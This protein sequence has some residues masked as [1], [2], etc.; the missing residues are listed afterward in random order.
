MAVCFCLY[1]TG[2]KSPRCLDV[3]RCSSRCHVLSA[4][5]ETDLV[6]D[7]F[8][9]GWCLGGGGGKGKPQS[10]RGWAG[11]MLIKRQDL[12]PC[13]IT[14][15]SMWR[16]DPWIHKTANWRELHSLLSLYRQSGFINV[17]MFRCYITFFYNNNLIWILNKYTDRS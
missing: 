7:G 10:R 9:G 2:K 3:E 16:H 4:G 14:K 11:G 6:V 8:R 17:I 1:V 13:V 12:S 15:V 5:T